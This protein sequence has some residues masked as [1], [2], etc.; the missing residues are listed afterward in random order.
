MCVFFCREREEGWG[1]KVESGLWSVLLYLQIVEHRYYF[2]LGIY[3][4]CVRERTRT[5]ASM[6]GLFFCL[7]GVF[8]VCFATCCVLMQRR[9]DERRRERSANLADH[10]MFGLLVE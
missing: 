3:N 7:A 1:S 10:A 6:S 4:L 8:N 2:A 9:C 5:C